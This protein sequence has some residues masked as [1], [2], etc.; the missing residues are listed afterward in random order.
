MRRAAIAVLA[1]AL[2]GTADARHR[3]DD[4]ID[5]PTDTRVTLVPGLWHDD[6]IAPGSG[7]HLYH[8][9][10]DAD[11]PVAFQMRAEVRGALWSY[12]RIVDA[13]NHEQSWAGV[14]N[15]RTN[16]CEVIVEVERGHAYDVIATSQQ[17]AVLARDAA[18]T[19]RGAYTIAAL[20]IDLRAA[21]AQIGRAH[22]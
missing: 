21:R 13:A 20:P 15:R 11:G 17:N 16:V 3:R 2:G 12:L 1:L 14:A 10:A 6:A 19:V 4:A 7:W 22:V 5:R 9:T 18:Q 8:F